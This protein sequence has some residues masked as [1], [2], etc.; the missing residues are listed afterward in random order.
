M[1]K[2]ALLLAGA[3]LLSLVAFEV[4]RWMTTPPP[5]DISSVLAF[6]GYDAVST[7]FQGKIYSRTS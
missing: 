5:V 2:L 7:S 3:V 4:T 1:Y 6:G